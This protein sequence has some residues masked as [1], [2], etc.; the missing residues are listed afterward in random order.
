MAIAE[1]YVTLKP[2]L[3]DVQGATVLKSLRQLGHE[4]V[5]NVRLGKY[6]SVE[7]DDALSATEI[8][9]ELD[10]ACQQLLANPVIEDYR[11]TLP[12]GAT[13]GTAT[14]ATGAS[15]ASGILV[16]DT[17]PNPQPSGSVGSAIPAAQPAQVSAPRVSAPQEVTTVT[18]TV[19]ETVT[20]TVA[21]APPTSMPLSTPA[22]VRDV[23][24]ADPFALEYTAYASLSPDERLALQGR[25]WQEHGA[26]ILGELESRRATWI[27]CVGPNVVASGET[28]DSYPTDARLAEFGIANDLAP[29]VFTRP[30]QD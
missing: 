15:L 30:P 19:V 12:G 16:T 25:A 5:Q 1:I 27:L 6:I 14:V 8:Q 13:S 23:H 18:Q 11:I 7:F 10:L 3:L 26:W 20:P 21:P 29:L 24:A 28:L 4:H 9:A 2:S 17:V 22:A